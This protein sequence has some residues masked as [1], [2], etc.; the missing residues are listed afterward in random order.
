[1]NNPFDWKNYEPHINMKDI[2]RSRRTSYQA[3]RIVNEKRK[4]GVEPSLPYSER[5]AAH[6]AATPKQMTVDMP[7]MLNHKKRRGKK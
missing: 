1:M 3:S 2:E 7:G 4:S 5:K 6:I